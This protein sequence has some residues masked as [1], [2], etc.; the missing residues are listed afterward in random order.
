MVYCL[1]NVFGKWCRPNYNS[2][3][4]TYCHSIVNGVPIQ[5][6]DPNRELN[7]V[8]IDDVIEEFINAMQGKANIQD[9]GFAHVKRSLFITLQ[10]LADTLQSFSE[11]RKTLIIPNFEDTMVKFLYATYL[12]YSTESS[13]I[14][15]LEMKHDNRGW[16]AEF[17]KSKQ[18]GQIFVSKTKPGNKRGEHWH[19]TK[20]EKF[21]VIH[22]KALI[23]LRQLHSNTVIQYEVSGDELRV[24][25]IPAGFTHSIT[26]IGDEDIITLFWAN[27][28]FDKNKPDTYYLEV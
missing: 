17:I 12:S 23:K 19:H 18:F 4:A 6:N 1:P 26:N 5:I 22:G 25:D 24:L 3:V 15:P 27:E 21:L 2:V 10:K 13:C 28:L 9:G 14:Y 11:N 8:Y 20:G 7:L 16:L